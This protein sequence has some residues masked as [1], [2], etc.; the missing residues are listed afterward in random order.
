VSLFDFVAN[1]HP[2]LC[3]Y[4][5]AGND[6]LDL[7]GWN[8]SSTIN[9]APGSFSSCDMMTNNVSIAKT[10]WLENAIGGGGND[11]IAG[12]IL[13]NVLDGGAGNDALTGAGGRDTFIYGLSY[14]ADTVTDF[15]ASGSDA[16]W[17]DLSAYLTI[18]NLTELLG[19]ATQSGSNTVFTF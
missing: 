15:A 4:D 9:L 17:I 14:G 1:P 16:D 11:T 2:V 12:N 3:I 18:D 6:T 10:A 13:N 8:T 7:S 5:A 19:L